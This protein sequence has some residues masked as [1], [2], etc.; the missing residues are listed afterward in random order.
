MGTNEF[1]LSELPADLALV[2]ADFDVD[3]NGTVSVA[4]LV[5]AATLMRSQA[6]K[7]S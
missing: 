1:I 5:T 4:E 2:L 6:R 7:A 3:G